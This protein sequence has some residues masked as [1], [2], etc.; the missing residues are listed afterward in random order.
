MTLY[1]AARTF[2]G[3]PFRHRGRK[4]H[5]DCAGL[6]KAA[7]QR[8]GVDLP[9]FLHYGREPHKDDLIRYIKD[10]LGDPVAT[11]PVKEYQLRPDDVIVLRFHVEP[12]HIAILGPYPHGG[13]AMIH[14][15]GHSKRVIEHRLSKDMINRITHVFRRPV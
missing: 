4:G 11:A 2:L 13:L 1:E 15:D 10:A 7:Y 8:C 3:T 14:A 12:H 9:D 6:G 5:L